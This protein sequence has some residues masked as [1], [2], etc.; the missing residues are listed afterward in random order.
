MP[1]AGTV[2]PSGLGPRDGEPAPPPVAA[3][4]IE[5][6]DPLHGK[7][8]AFVDDRISELLRQLAEVYDIV[9]TT[10]WAQGVKLIEQATGIAG[11]QL[12]PASRM[13]GPPETALAICQTLG[14][15]PR[16]FAWLGTSFT[17]AEELTGVGVPYL[18]ARVDPDVGLGLA[19]TQA[20]IA[21]QRALTAA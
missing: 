15:R 1:I 2:L 10:D 21:W 18:L 11:T 9:W 16:A 17:D 20:L 6:H 3:R 14:E 19:Q 4:Q 5:W 13:D 7:L 8:H 12:R